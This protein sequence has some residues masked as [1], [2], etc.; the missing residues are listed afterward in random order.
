MEVKIKNIDFDKLKA[1][2]KILL[3]M[4]QD[5]SES[6]DPR[7]RSDSREAE[8]LLNL[9]DEIQDYA[10]DI[11]GMK[12]HDVFNCPNC[13]SEDTSDASIRKQNDAPRKMGGRRPKPVMP[14]ILDIRGCDGCGVIFKPTKGNGN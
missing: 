7:N 12:E 9:I 1:Q 13:G 11:L 2:K 3:N 4:M 8:G 14:K 6:D 5:W 10:I